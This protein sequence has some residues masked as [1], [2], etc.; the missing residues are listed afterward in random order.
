MT[1]ATDAHLAAQYEAYP[2]PARQP[3]DEAKRLIIGSPGHLREIDHWVFAASRPAS[4][5]LRALIAGGG[6]GDATIMLAT[7]LTRAGRPGDVTWLDRST[8]ARG[9]AQARAKQRGLRNII[10]ET[11]SILELPGSGLGPFDY[12]DCCGVLHHL[13][14]PAEGLAVLLSVLAP[15]GGLGLMVYAPYGRT[16]VY[17]LQDALRRLAPAEAPPATRLDVARR[18]MKH[19]P[20]TA[21]LR[22]NQNFG[23][24]IEGGDAGLY[25]L[26]LNPRDRAFDIPALFGLLKGAG[27]QVTC[28]MEP[29]RYDPATWLPDPKLR[30]L[31][32]TLDPVGS[33][34]LA[35]CLTGNMS[36]HVVYCTRADAAPNGPDPLAP[37]AV[38][39]V[40]EM[41]G[42]AMAAA[43][44]PD[45][46]LPLVI[47]G[48][49]VPL[50][51][52]A[53]A[54]AILKLIDG[55][56]RVTDIEAILMAR[57]VQ[58]SAFARSWAAC[59]SALSRSN[60]VL[61]APPA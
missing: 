23:D 57:G 1:D 61:L 42:E 15:G 24:H 18:V 9:I 30:A 11:R 27:L 34:A 46:T 22:R 58:A 33:A 39:I 45:G 38:P 37:N 50:A 5:P 51:L 31:A 21:W 56:R 8:A 43:I 40:R 6:T 20:E 48:L 32:A 53:L 41:P 60:R 7:Q 55:T 25:D 29:L 47:D 12:I 4:R 59:W 28:L 54:P 16:G 26:L 35:E 13:P 10:W 19:L 36:T 52:P 49:R 17:M 3:L 2:Y 14:D 44:R